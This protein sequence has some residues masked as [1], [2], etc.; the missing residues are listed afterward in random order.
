MYSVSILPAGNHRHNSFRPR[1]QWSDANYRGLIATYMDFV[2]HAESTHSVSPVNPHLNPT[3]IEQ[4]FSKFSHIAPRNCILHALQDCHNL[5]EEPYE[6]AMNPMADAYLKRPQ[7]NIRHRNQWDI[8]KIQRMIDQIAFYHH[9]LTLLR[10]PNDKQTIATI[11]NK[12]EERQRCIQLHPTR[13][14]RPGP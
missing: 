9:Q 3:L 4:A 2:D 6:L 1:W 10:L 11:T 12:I 13:Y 8:L 5:E 7:I 14:Y